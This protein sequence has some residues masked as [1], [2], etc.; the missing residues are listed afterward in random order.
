[1][2][3]PLLGHLDVDVGAWLAALP[4]ELVWATTW[5][6]EANEVLAPILCLP[7]LPVR[8]WPEPSVEDTYFGLHPKTHSLIA[9]AGGEDFAWVD[10]EITEA[11]RESIAEH[12]SGA[13]LLLPV[14]PHYGLTATDLAS[15][16]G[17][18]LGDR[19]D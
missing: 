7:G 1:M 5:M 6:Q 18:L 17:W 8:D 16:E 19:S 2:K 4:A 10:D 12:D 11:D 9:W 14:D 3:S 15:L 13:F